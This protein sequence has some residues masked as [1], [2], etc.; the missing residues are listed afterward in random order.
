MTDFSRWCDPETVV[1]V[2]EHT[3]GALVSNDDE[4]G[5]DAVAA[6]LPD[7]YAEAETLAR[8]ADRH[9]KKGVSKLLREKVPTKQ[10][11]RSGD[12]GEILATA[13]L[14][15]NMDYAVGPSR[16][17]YRDH[18]EWAMRG[19][20][21]LGARLDDDEL[22]LA[23]VEAKSRAKASEAVVSEARAGLE[24][25]NGLPS[26]H[27]LTQFAERLLSTAD[28]QL[29]DLIMDLQIGAGVRPSQVTHVMFLFTGNDP[30]QHVRGDLSA[31]TGP[32][33]Q[34]TV[35]LRVTAHQDFIRESFDRA[36][37]DGT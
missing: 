29:G 6:T 7:K 34:R 32:M 8:I 35:I 21:V 12:M 3:V 26:S 19:D 24:R 23:K 11:A 33:A 22:K 2:G 25:E 20:D 28:D 14:E 4:T 37:D 15:E 31:Y 10:S 13:Y 9:G 18:Q 27:S 17:I 5:I 1:P 16:L 30:S 36:L